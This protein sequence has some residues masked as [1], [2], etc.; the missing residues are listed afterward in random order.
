MTK[1]GREGGTKCLVVTI[2]SHSL[3]IRCRKSK[4]QSRF[5]SNE[6]GM[7]E[8]FHTLINVLV[9]VDD[10]AGSTVSVFLHCFKAPCLLQH[11]LKCRITHNLEIEWSNSCCEEEFVPNLEGSS[12]RIPGNDVTTIVFIFFSLF[13]HGS[14]VFEEDWFHPTKAR[15]SW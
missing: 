10:V 8:R 4:A 6:F 12:I 2:V 7:A 13:Q 15:R 11:T 9:G 5:S 14:K 3:H 1:G